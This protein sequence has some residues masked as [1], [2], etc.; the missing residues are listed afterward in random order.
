[1]NKIVFT[2]TTDDDFITKP[3]PSSHVIPD[4]YKQTESYRGGTKGLTERL[5][6]N[7]TIKKCMPVFDAMTAGYIL[8]TAADIFVKQ[9]N[10]KPVFYWSNHNM[11]EFHEFSQGGL[12][13][14]IQDQDGDLPKFI[15]HWAIKTPKGY[16]TLFV[17]P[18][19]RK[20]IFAIFPGVV[21]TDEFNTPVNF[22]FMLKDLT[23][24]GV[25]PAGTPIVQVIPFKRESW[26]MELGGEKE[27]KLHFDSLKRLQNKFFD[28]YK[29]LMRTPKEYK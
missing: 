13:P 10:G 26:Q 14:S 21:D 7:G 9:E 8:S 11:I 29:S 3:K 24:E 25:I 5:N 19:H 17:A 4:W 20:E 27:L 28:R 18:F 12:H 15:N 23:F 6:T 16:S 1:M 2:N 22:P